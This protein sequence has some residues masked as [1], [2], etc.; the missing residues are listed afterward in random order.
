M[1]D[2]Y[3]NF[4]SLDIFCTKKTMTIAPRFFENN[5]YPFCATLTYYPCKTQQAT[6]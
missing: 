3:H 1:N 5:S 6:F 2:Q 4:I